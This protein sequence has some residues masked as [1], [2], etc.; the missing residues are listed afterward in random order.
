MCNIF[1][2]DVCVS[3][4]SI[5]IFILFEAHTCKEVQMFFNSSGKLVDIFLSG[6]KQILLLSFYCVV[7]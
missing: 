3:T 4:V 6:E 2:Y 5:L 1:T 7:F